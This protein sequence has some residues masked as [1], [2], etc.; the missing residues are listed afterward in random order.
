MTVP[1][2]SFPPIEITIRGFILPSASLSAIF[3][4]V[5]S[6]AAVLGRSVGGD[7]DAVQSWKAYIDLASTDSP[8]V[9]SVTFF[10]HK[11]V[12]VLLFEKVSQP[13]KITAFC[14]GG[15]ERHQTD[16]EESEEEMEPAEEREGGRGERR[17]H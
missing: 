7:G 17:G 10:W 15:D 11:K 12:G 9:Q 16:E 6:P 5:G 8:L 3:E 1:L 4:E 2:F 14:E 13:R